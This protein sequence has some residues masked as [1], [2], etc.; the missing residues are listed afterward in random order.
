MS[1]PMLFDESFS[2]LLN[3]VRTILGDAALDKTLV[4][5]EAAGRL[6]FFYDGELTTEELEVLEKALREHLGPYA[7]PDRV[8]ADRRAPGAERVLAETICQWL[9]YEGRRI[10]YVDRRIVGA[11]WLISPPANM[12]DLVPPRFVFASIKGGVGRTTALCVAAADLARQG[13]NILVV[14]LDLE[15]PGLGSLLLREQDAPKFGAIDY[16]VESGIIKGAQLSSLVPGLVAPSFL[17]MREGGRVDV[18][19]AIGATT[20][21]ENYLSKLAHALLDVGPEGST[22]TVHMKIGLLLDALTSGQSYDAVFVDARAGLAELAA[23]PML[24]LGATVLLFG[25]A[26]RQTIEDYRLLFAHLAS[27]VKPEE[28]SPWDKLRIVLAKATPNAEQHRWF[29]EELYSLFQDYL[30]EEQ[31][32]LEG[33]NFPED[34]T[35]APHYPIPIALNPIFADW[36]PTRRH[37]ELTQPFY[38]SSFRPFITEL[39]KR[40]EIPR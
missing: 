8:V 18:V 26:Q 9:P 3:D 16:L 6:T 23:G 38:E 25:T 19:P 22:L 12:E 33:F 15:A 5:R 37:D 28:E 35:T 13:K 31:E 7:R 36:E 24:G 34:D 40:I 17:T 39:K 1:Q 29:R 2:A 20:K 10:R 11:D 30:Y 21:P 14:D 32:E 27:L 4:H